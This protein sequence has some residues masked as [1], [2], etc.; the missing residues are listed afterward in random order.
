[1]LLLLLAFAS[2]LL[3]SRLE[4][5]SIYLF[6]RNRRGLKF[7]A[8]V[9]WRQ[10]AREHNATKRGDD[11]ESE[12]DA[13]SPFDGETPLD[14][15]WIVF[16]RVRIN[17]HTVRGE[18]GN[19]VRNWEMPQGAIAKLERANRVIVVPDARIWFEPWVG[20]AGFTL[21]EYS[22][23]QQLPFCIPS[24]DSGRWTTVTATSRVVI[25]RV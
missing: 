5:G 23:S 24:D 2:T 6:T 17:V 22:Y 10:L 4:S 8:R 13:V 3:S 25:V 19:W 20:S 14:V 18:R 15:K 21:S 1:M 7:I 16:G 9:W 11:P 12:R